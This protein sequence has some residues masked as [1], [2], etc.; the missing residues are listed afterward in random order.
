[1]VLENVMQP[2]KHAKHYYKWLY[3]V[4]DNHKFDISSLLYLGLKKLSHKCSF[5]K[6][7]KTE[8]ILHEYIFTYLQ[9]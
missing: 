9:W 2:N 1:M 3:V 6:A 4:I 8:K 5:V 7:L